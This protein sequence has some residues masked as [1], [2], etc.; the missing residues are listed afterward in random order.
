[1]KYLFVE[2]RG[3]YMTNSQLHIQAQK[4]WDSSVNIRRQYPT[5]EFYWHELYERV[6]NISFTKSVFYRIIKPAH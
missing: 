3:C 4:E 1:M 6:Y 2:E 5:F